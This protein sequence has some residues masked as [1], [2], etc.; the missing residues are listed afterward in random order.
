MIMVEGESGL[1]GSRGDQPQHGAPVT[2]HVRR[3]SA[4]DLHTDAPR[5]LPAIPQLR[6]L[7]AARTVT[8][9]RFTNAGRGRFDTDVALGP[10]A[11]PWMVR[12]VRTNPPHASDHC[13]Q[14]LIRR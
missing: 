11:D 2:A 1:E 6:R 10:V 12:S 5:L 3:S 8:S 14:E 4:A 9:A 13:I 7:Q